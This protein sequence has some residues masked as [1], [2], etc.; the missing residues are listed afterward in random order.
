MEA[1][2]PIKK[3]P[4][5]FGDV[6]VKQAGIAENTADFMKR[7]VSGLIKTVPELQ[8]D[9]TDWLWQAQGK[10]KDVPQ[11]VCRSRTQ[12]AAHLACPLA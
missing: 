7:A 6:A 12:P 9:R 8:T 5:T 10:G 11:R 3:F 2:I 1:A 4:R